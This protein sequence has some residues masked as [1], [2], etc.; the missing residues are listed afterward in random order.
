VSDITER[1]RSRH[2][3]HQ[4]DAMHWSLRDEAADEI[5]RL[6]A[7]LR[8]MRDLLRESQTPVCIAEK[9]H[10]T[11]NLLGRIAEALAAARAAIRE[12]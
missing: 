5:D 1:L 12:G 2:W 11:N 6:R 4:G 3:P 9:T 10:D 8:D 7:A